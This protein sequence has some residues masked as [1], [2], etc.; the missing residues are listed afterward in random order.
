MKQLDKLEKDSDISED[1]KKSLSDSVQKLTD[2]YVEKID[3][4]IKMKQ[5]DVT[6]V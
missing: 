6:R 4:L 1:L 2:Q 3:K 5:D